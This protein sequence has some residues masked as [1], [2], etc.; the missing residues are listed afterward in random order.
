MLKYVDAEEHCSA[1]NAEQSECCI[2]LPA[3]YAGAGHNSSISDLGLSD[4]RDH[5]EI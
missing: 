3:V 4:V 1:Y 2:H 5:S